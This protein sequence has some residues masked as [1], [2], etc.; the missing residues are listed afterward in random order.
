LAICSCTPPSLAGVYSFGPSAAAEMFDVNVRG[1]ETVLREALSLGVERAVYTSTVGTTAFSGHRL[2]SES[3]LA[4]PEAMCGPYKR[5][6]YEAERFVRRLARQGAPIVTVCPTAPI[7]PGDRKPTPTG[8]I[9]LDFMRGKIPAYIDTGLN[10]VHVSDAAE[11]HLLAL[12]SGAP[13]ARYLLGN[14]E[15][16]LTLAQAFDIL[17]GA[18]GRPAPRLRIPYPLALA[19]ARIDSLAAGALPRRTPSIP[20]EG[21][22]MARTRMWVDPSWSVRELGLPQTPIETAFREAVDWFAKHGR[23]KGEFG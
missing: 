15:G 17:A 19:A 10:F 2:A 8:R 5:S 11:G 9:V 3:D 16:N 13:G 20:L 7:G 18:A 23:A 1:T 21:V 22:R 4:G 14:A 12:E 6:K